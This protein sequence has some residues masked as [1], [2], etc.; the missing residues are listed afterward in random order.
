MRKYMLFDS[1]SLR[2]IQF[3]HFPRI[4][5]VSIF[6]Q[7]I[8]QSSFVQLLN[9]FNMQASIDT[10]LY[11]TLPSSQKM[12]TNGYSKISELLER[13]IKLSLLPILPVYYNCSICD[14]VDRKFRSKDSM[15]EH[16]KLFHCLKCS[17]CE[18]GHETFET[19]SALENHIKDIHSIKCDFCEDCD[20]QTFVSK[21]EL[22]DHIKIHHNSF[23]KCN[24]CDNSEKN[25]EFKT[26]I[27][28]RAHINFEHTEKC[29]F[30]DAYK[31]MDTM[32]DHIESLH[33]IE[34]QYEIGE[35][36]GSGSFGEIYIGENVKSNEKVAI[37]LETIKD[38]VK[39][40]LYKEYHFY[41]LLGNHKGIPEM[42]MLDKFKEKNALVLEL[43]GPDLMHLMKKCGGKFSLQTVKHIAVEVIHILEFIHSKHLLHCDIKPDNIVIGRNST[44]KENV[45]HL[46]DFGLSKKYVI[47][48]GGKDIP[49]KK[50]KGTGSGTVRY[51]SINTHL[52]F[53]PSRK[54]DMESF[55][56]VLVYLM[57][58]KLPWQGLKVKSKQEHSTKVCD[59][60]SSISVEKLCEGCPEEFQK[61]MTSCFH[62]VKNL[63]YEETPNYSFVRKLF[64]SDKY[65]DNCNP[66]LIHGDNFKFDWQPET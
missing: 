44:L 24:F 56:Y 27:A 25:P 14:L 66:P 57:K 19:K 37:K 40:K 50:T 5:Y 12:M 41:Q 8:F 33:K 13:S 42:Y 52:G 47:S 20:S 51:M 38:R 55:G 2:R 63:E 30:C 29:K 48:N 18:E 60:K 28:L 45:I 49:R 36:I 34:S 3:R 58:G 22:E 7:F 16:L 54:D 15:N 35:K 21:P 10:D 1:H 17:Y 61:I 62:H 65:F 64:S 32:G 59:I 31:A 23:F 26:E 6:S 43:L 39:P 9:D 4:P 53:E 11:K 46:V